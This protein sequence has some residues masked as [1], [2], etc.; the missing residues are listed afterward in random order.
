M[1]RVDFSARPAPAVRSARPGWR[2]LLLSL[3]LVITTGLLVWVFSLVDWSEFWRVL[4][5]SRLWIVGLVVV[6]RFA[7]LALSS[8]KWQQLLA[9]H[10]VRYRLGRLL[11]LYLVGSFLNHFLPGSI[12]GDGY[13]VYKTW[14]NE[15]GRSAS[16]LAIVLERLTGIGALALLGYGAA[17]VLLLQGARGVAAGLFAAGSAALGAAVVLA[18]LSKR[19]RLVR[20]IRSTRLW[21][22]SLDAVGALAHDFRRESGRTVLV[23]GLSVLF[24]LNKI[25]VVW[26][27]LYAL[28]ATANP[29]AVAVA[30]LIVELAGLLPISLGGLGVVEGSFILVIGQFG[31]GEEVALATMLLMRLL[32]VPFDVL[33]AFFYAFGDRD[34]NE[35]GSKQSGQARVGVEP[36]H[37][38]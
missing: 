21:P 11:R 7:G 6:M 30:L 8:F 36:V 16:I 32:M 20:R 38:K 35:H 23:G 25:L 33:G 14:R 13:R 24:H 2:R 28:G 1:V 15:R 27:L 9:I 18:W 3:K 5:A 31:V 22:R 12:G 4:A 19:F 17:L 34:G 26:L 37:A 29:L 10:S